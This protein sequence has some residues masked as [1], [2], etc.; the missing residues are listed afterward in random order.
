MAKTTPSID[1]PKIH[2]GMKD[3]T[4]VHVD[5]GK[6]P[7]PK[8]AHTQN[9]PIHSGMVTKSRATGQWHWGA[10]SMG[11]Y[12]ADPASPLGSPPIQKRLTPPM[13]K[14]GMKSQQSPQLSEDQHFALGKSIL[15]SATADPHNPLYGSTPSRQ[16][17]GTVSEE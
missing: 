11:R 8:R 17:P 7:L 14:P 13:I 3:V 2:S 6:P 9:V 15:D 5:L 4:S 12:D 16:L 1:A 10:D